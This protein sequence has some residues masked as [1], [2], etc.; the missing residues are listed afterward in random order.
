MRVRKVCVSGTKGVGRGIG[1][2]LMLSCRQ[3]HCVLEAKLDCAN[4][5]RKDGIARACV[6]LTIMMAAGLGRR[7]LVRK[8]WEVVEAIETVFT[9]RKMLR[10]CD[11]SSS[12]VGV[13]ES[14]CGNSI[15]SP[16]QTRKRT[17]T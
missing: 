5:T 1:A 12:F 9:F 2:A 13:C 4:G 8:F 16:S 7:G 3:R 14:S 10:V 15:Q 11:M 6:G 17:I